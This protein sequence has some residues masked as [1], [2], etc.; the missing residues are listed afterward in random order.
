MIPTASTFLARHSFSAVLV[1]VS[2]GGP[3]ALLEL[4]KEIGNNFPLP[5]FIT[6]HIDSS[7]DKELITWLSSEAAVPV[8]LAENDIKPLPG[9]VYFAPSDAHLTFKT[10]YKGEFR[11]ELNYDVPVNYVRP[12]VDKMFESAAKVFGGNC[13]AV[14]LTGM[15]MDGAKGCLNLKNLGAYTIAQ[16]EASCTIYGMP[17]A[18]FETG[19]ACEVLPL[20]KIAKRLWGL[21]GENKVLL[22]PLSTTSFISLISN[23]IL[24]YSGV[25][26]SQTQIPALTAYI[27][28][29]AAKKQLP[30]MEYCEKLAPNMPDFNTIINLVTVKET[31]FFREEMQFDYLKKEVFPKYTGKNLSIWTCCCATGEEPISLMALALSMNV[32]LTLYASDIDITALET[33]RRGRFLLYS[34]RSDGEKYHKLLEPYSTRT[35]TE[36]VFKRSF[37]DRIQIFQFNL[38]GGNKALPFNTVDI[39]FMRNVFIYFDKETRAVVTRKI[40]EHLNNGGK[41]FFSMNEVGSVDDMVVPKNLLKTNS[42][43]VYYFT[44]GTPEEKHRK[45]ASAQRIAAARLSAAARKAYGTSAI[46]KTTVTKPA[47]KLTA[48]IPSTAAASEKTVENAEFNIKNTYEDICDNI[49]RGDFVKARTT[50]R[51]ITGTEN[52]KYSFFLQGYVEYH[53]DNRAAAE[54]LFASTES[55]SP[56]FWPATFYHGMVLRDLG[57]AERAK[58]CFIKCKNLISRFGQKVPYD[59]T[60]DSFSPSYIYSLCETLSGENGSK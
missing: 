41:L 13:I 37:L 3:T 50:A 38:L 58:T 10:Y 26:V 56:D 22:T 30:V 51:S 53:A 28:K 39:I 9:H 29:Q 55:L 23:K 33:F 34:L 54:T 8:H 46:P 49:S 57:K 12:A 7:F 17:K 44:K 24:D 11:I 4:L 16:D 48:A 18:V 5:I 19:G 27:E 14:V 36:L 45:P 32:N 43:I 60:L 15:G 31:Y 52:K 21:V 2:T 42:G 25:H 47:A 6:Q 59:F 1:G 40:A 35:E 20:N